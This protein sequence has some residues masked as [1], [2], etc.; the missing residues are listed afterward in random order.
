M[1]I[2]IY[3]LMYI[4]IYVCKCI[5]YVH[6]MYIICIYT[7]KFKCP[8]DLSMR[9][10][11]D[12][13]GL[14]YETQSTSHTTLIFICLSST[15]SIHTHTHTHTHTHMHNTY[16]HTCIYVVRKAYMFE[17]LDDV[18]TMINMNIVLKEKR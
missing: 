7:S 11:W 2:R 3:I 16:I 12:A 1:Y 6:H 8:D 14:V 13:A 15:G 5:T 4:H 17:C 18:F 9:I 10:W